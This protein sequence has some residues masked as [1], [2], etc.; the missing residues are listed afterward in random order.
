MLPIFLL[1]II[2]PTQIS[3]K[4][5]LLIFSDT[6]KDD[7]GVQGPKMEDI[8]GIMWKIEL[9]WKTELQNSKLSK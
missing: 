9:M 4:G 2:L 6:K 5:V 3:E 7:K 1:Y 8:H